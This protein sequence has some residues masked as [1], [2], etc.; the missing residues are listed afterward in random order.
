MP[1]DPVCGTEINEEDAR[2]TTGQT[3]HGASE[4]DPQAGTRIFHDGSWFYFCSLDCRSKFLAS[5]TTYLEQSG[6]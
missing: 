5:P 2:S 4:V 6:T 3:M 1:K